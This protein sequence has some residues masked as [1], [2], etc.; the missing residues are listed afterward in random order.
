MGIVK[1]A[2]RSGQGYD[3]EAS[4]ADAPWARRAGIAIFAAPGGY[5]R[6]VFGVVEL[7]G[8]A[9]DIQP[10]WALAEAER[11]GATEVF[12]RH[13]AATDVRRAVLD[14]LEA[15]LSPVCTR[16]GSK[17][18]SPAGAGETLADTVFAAAA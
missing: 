5:G 10:I 6:R 17:N 4:G 15:G 11:F 18:A 14:D 1:F 12:V 7:T 13:E 16:G 8:R 2:G 9:H 3:F